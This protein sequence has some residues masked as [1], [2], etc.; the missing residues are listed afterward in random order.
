MRHQL[1][2]RDRQRTKTKLLRTTP[3][4]CKK[5]NSSCAIARS[6]WLKS[7]PKSPRS[8]INSHP[9]QSSPALTVALSAASKFRGKLTTTFL[10]NLLLVSVAVLHLYPVQAQEKVSPPVPPPPQRQVSPLPVPPPPSETNSTKP[11]SPDG[12][13]I[14]DDTEA[15]AD[16]EEVIEDDTGAPA[17]SDQEGKLPASDSNPLNPAGDSLDNLIQQGIN[18]DL[19]QQ[20]RGDLPCV[21]ATTE[22]IAQLQETATQQNPLLIEIDARIEEINT[23]IEEAK[24]QNKKSINLSV[25]RPAAR[26]F[27]EPTFDASSSQPNQRQRGPIEKLVSIF[28]SPVGVINEVLR[29][30]GIPLFDK[31]LGGGN[32][33]AQGRSIAIADLQVK[34]AEIQRGRAELANQVKEKVALAVFDFDASRRDFQIS[35]EISKRESQRMQLSEVEYR[36]GEGD[37]ETYLGQ[38]SSLDRNKAATWHSWASM[39]SQLEKIKLLVLGIPE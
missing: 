38:L 2:Q 24:A 3:A 32:E 1:P 7:L 34:L 5:Q 19:W 29:A 26:V 16:S 35:Q 25:L 39:R 9:S 4:S 12:E 8:I 33:Q 22:C 28:T 27:L 11:I 37:S 31:L 18:A 13:V 23:K 17:P 14:E 10:S 36:L 15:P 20:M 21:D 6:S 30:V